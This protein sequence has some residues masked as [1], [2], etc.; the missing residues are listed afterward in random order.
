MG[1]LEEPGG[2]LFTRVRVCDEERVFV[3]RVV[4]GGQRRGGAP[5]WRGMKVV[6]M[7]VTDCGGIAGLDGVC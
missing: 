5:P 3:A 7:P 4:E 6:T 1:E 2:L